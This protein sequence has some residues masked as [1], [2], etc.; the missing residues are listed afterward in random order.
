M[1]TQVEKNTERIERLAH[2]SIPRLLIHYGVPA[3]VGTMVN[4]LYSVVDRI[5][6]GQGVSEFAITGLALTFPILIFIQAFGMLI[7][8]GASSRV[9]ILLG[10]NKHDQ[11]ERILSNALLLT[12]VT[13]VL[14]LVP[15]MIWLDDIL[16]A[17]G[18]NDRTLPFAYDYLKIM[19][20]GNIF[21]TLCF[22][23][24]AVMRA[25]GYPYKAMVTMLIG[26]GLNTVLDAIFIYV[27]DWGIEGAAWATV[28][29]MAV[30]SAFVMQH[31]LSSKSEVQFRRR[32]M[33]LSSE[34]ILAIL[35]IGMSPFFL[36][37]LSSGITFLI[38]STLARYAENPLMADRA[39]GAYGIINSAALVGFMFMLGIAQGMQPI[40]G[41]NYG[42]RAMD[43]VRQTFKI[44]SSTNFGIGAFVTIVAVVAPGLIASL[45][46]SSP[47]MIEASAHALRLCL[48]GFAFVGFQVTATQFF[49]SI[50]FGGKA[51][52]LSLSRQILFLL[53]ALFLFPLLWGSTGVWLAMPFSDIAAGVLGMILMYYQ[54]KI[55]DRKFGP[56]GL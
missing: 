36:Q 43:R 56:E 20:P 51:L 17:L 42:A 46:T 39:V 54:F 25:S 28:I 30:S 3:I 21:S 37:L 34:Q 4:A 8:V 10:E 52:L 47:E 33:R 11:A 12:L 23:F 50:G 7:G 40:V 16:R 41:Y 14:T 15:V 38:N 9:S 31:F 19:I 27:F 32:N 29:A 2:E 45:F 24:N 13:Q 1:S 5:F 49:Q 48:Y 22:S 18:A 53:P 26:A 44:C 35:S 55:F 6:I